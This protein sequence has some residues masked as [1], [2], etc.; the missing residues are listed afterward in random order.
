VPRPTAAT[1]RG[2]ETKPDPPRV[3]KPAFR[4]SRAGCPV[5]LLSAALWNWTSP[6]ALTVFCV[7]TAE[8]TDGPTAFCVCTAEEL[9]GPTETSVRSAA[10]ALLASPTPISTAN[11]V[12]RGDIADSWFPRRAPERVTDVRVLEVRRQAA[13]AGVREGSGRGARDCGAPGLAHG[14]CEAGPGAPAP[15]GRVVL[16]LK[17]PQP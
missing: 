17:P 5:V 14:R 16:R 8:N 3:W 9:N 11:A 4:S 2:R 10:P 13:G 15:S 6:A 12:I 1:T 7:R